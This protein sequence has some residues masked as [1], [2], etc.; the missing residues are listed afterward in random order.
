VPRGGPEEPLTIEELSAKFRDCSKPVIG[1]GASERALE[2][3]LGLEDLGAV[4]ELMA[5]I[6]QSVS[7][8]AV[9]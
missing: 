6:G 1:A 8:S 2:L 5:V 4:S 9:G 3:L 7:L